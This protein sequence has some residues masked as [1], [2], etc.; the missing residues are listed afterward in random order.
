MVRPEQGFRV[1]QAESGMQTPRHPLSLGGRQQVVMD[2]LPHSIAAVQTLPSPVGQLFPLAHVPVLDRVDSDAQHASGEQSSCPVQEVAAPD[3]ELD[4]VL[5]FEL[6]TELKLA[7]EVDTEL[8]PLPELYPDAELEPSPELYADAE[9]EPLP[10][11]YPDADSEAELEPL[12]EL[13]PA[14]ELDPGGVHAVF[15][16]QTRSV[17]PAHVSSPHVP[18]AQGMVLSHH[19]APPP[20]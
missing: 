19:W 11:L 5:D 6:E 20:P 13:P 9:L 14:P 8:E 15:P 17:V 7:L 10:E 12:P 16:E 3:P 2:S 4:P 18:I 1:Q